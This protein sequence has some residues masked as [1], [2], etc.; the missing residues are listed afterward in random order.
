MRAVTLNSVPETPALADLPI[1]RPEPGEVLVKV[2]GSSVNGFDLSVAAGYV[3]QML[4][5]RFPLV[6]GKDFAGTVEALGEG[7]EGFTVGQPVFGVVMKP[8]LGP[9]AMAEYLTVPAAY[10]IAPLPDGLAVEEAGALGL[11]GTAA[12][13]SL[14][15]VAPA[16][17]DRRH[18]LL[19]PL[20]AT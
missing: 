15:A 4:E 10:G 7:V 19:K 1:P 16:R 6:V 18:L 12:L 9:G 14:N 11:A 20:P 3:R 2:A 8:F 13:D 17:Q 5:H